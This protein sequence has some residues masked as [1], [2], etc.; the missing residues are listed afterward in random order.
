MAQQVKEPV[1][2]LLWRSFDPWPGDF[3]VPKGAARERKRL[4]IFSHS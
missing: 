2:S 3:Y 4:K 1:S